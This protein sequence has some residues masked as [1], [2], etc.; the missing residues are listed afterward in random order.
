MKKGFTLIELMAVIIIMGVLAVIGVPKLYGLAAKAKASEIQPAAGTYIHLQEAFTSAGKTAFGN[1]ED[2]GYKAPGDGKGESRNFCYSQGTL[3]TS[4]EIASNE[5]GFIGWGAT[6]K[7]QL[8]DCLANSWWSITT[9]GTEKGAITYNQYVSSG[10]C[11]ALL[12]NWESGATLEGDCETATA[13]EPE[14]VKPETPENP[15]T[16]KTDEGSDGEKKDPE[17]KTDDTEKKEETPLTPE[18]LEKQKKT[19]LQL[20][21]EA[22]KADIAYG[23][24]AEQALAA[25]TAAKSAEELA[26]AAEKTAAFLQNEAEKAQERADEAIIFKKTAQKAADEAQKLAD[27]QEA[28]AEKLRDKADKAQANADQKVAEANAAKEAAEKARTLAI[29]AAKAADAQAREDIKDNIKDD[30]VI[31]GI[32]RTA[33]DALESEHE[34]P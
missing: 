19:L 11:Q 16:E 12:A 23:I 28:A 33:E 21:E 5:D 2:I 1:W 13:K 4:I 7:N 3:T 14:A 34:V 8:K 20:L 22:S 25:V 30:G 17:E 27:A 18:E 6:N 29:N 15:E 9:T 26:K 32:I 24:A 31:G 10:E